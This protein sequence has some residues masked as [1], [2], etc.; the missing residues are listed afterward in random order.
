MLLEFVITSML[1][2]QFKTRCLQVKS[3]QQY[4]DT[5]EYEQDFEDSGS[6]FEKE[7]KAKDR[8]HSLEEYSNLKSTDLSQ[9]QKFN[10][11]LTKTPWPRHSEVM[12]KISN[13]L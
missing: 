10:R 12:T 9:K 6:D 2:F 4:L 5:N 8:Q 1:I 13:F 3:Y 7:L 11:G